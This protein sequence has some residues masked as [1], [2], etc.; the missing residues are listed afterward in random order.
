MLSD[1]MQQCANLCRCLI[2]NPEPL[3]VEEPFAA[4]D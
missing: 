4:L 2:H 1:G 3:M